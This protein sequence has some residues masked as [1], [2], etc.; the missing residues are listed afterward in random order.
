MRT[1]EKLTSCAKIVGADGGTLRI[2]NY[3]DVIIPNGALYKNVKITATIFAPDFSQ[4][5]EIPITPIVIMEPSGLNFH[6]PVKMR[7][8]TWRGLRFQNP[9]KCVNVLGKSCLTFKHAVSITA[10]NLVE[11]ETWHFSSFFSTL[12]DKKAG[13]L[14]TYY[15]FYDSDENKIVFYFGIAEGIESYGNNLSPNYIC[16]GCQNQLKVNLGSALTC[17]IRSN[18]SVT[19]KE[20]KVPITEELIKQNKNVHLTKDFS[21]GDKLEYTINN[22]NGLEIDR[23]TLSLPM[24]RKYSE[25]SLLY[26]WSSRAS[27]RHQS[28]S[29]HEDV[30]GKKVFMGN[31][32]IIKNVHNHYY[33]CNG[34]SVEYEMFSCE[35]CKRE[36]AD[37]KDL[38]E[39]HCDLEF[40]R[41]RQT[42][43]GKPQV[44]VFSVKNPHG[45]CFNIVTFNKIIDESYKEV[46]EAIGWATWFTGYKWI[47]C[48]CVKCE[49]HIGWKYVGDK[50]QFFGIITEKEGLRD[51]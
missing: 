15:I 16:I 51:R 5:S 4:S 35:N 41:E 31:E 19:P 20:F 1:T 13:V 29:I 17:H 34:G 28:F 49:N 24:S 44:C 39:I 50:G 23:N 38:A 43:C 47:I 37:G 11:F 40:K 10:S 2:K 6:K 45:Y 27:G 8:R 7:L 12:P 21:P 30:I 9:S 46:S 3:C 33:N 14:L 18:H 32:N 26:S 42:I 36:I 25:K 22:D 48:R